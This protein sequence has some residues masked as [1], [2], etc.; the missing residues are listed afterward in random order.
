MIAVILL[1]WNNAPDT[2]ECLASVYASDDPNFSVIVADN[3]SEDDSVACLQ[4]AYPQARTLLNGENL[5]FAEGNNRAIRLAMEEGAQ[6]V[7]LLNNDATIAKETLSQLRQAAD[8]HPNAAVVGPTIY[9]YDDPTTIW[10]GIGEVDVEKGWLFTRARH[11]EG[12][13]YQAIEPAEYIS[14]CAFFARVSHLRIS[15][16][17]DPRFFLNWEEPDWC[18]RLRKLGF[19]C[20]LV[21]PAKAWHKVSRSFGGHGPLWHY[22]MYRNRFL[23]ME[24]HL[25]R[26]ER[27]RIFKTHV[28]AELLSML[29]NVL[30]PKEGAI[31]RA[32]LA[33]FRDYWLRRFGKGPKRLFRKK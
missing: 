33:G 25:P 19:D 6:Y 13:F 26:S 16:L 32:A 20:L 28:W 22:F 21:G 3:G 10:F 31:H 11:R 1:N 23:W 15:G 5:G 12:T 8:A 2:L 24:I 4:R 30:H 7:F 29:Q 18:F 14:G 27:I 9:Y 17:M